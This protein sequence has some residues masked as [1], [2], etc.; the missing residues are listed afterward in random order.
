MICQDHTQVAADGSR[1]CLLWGNNAP[2]DVGGYARS[3]NWPPTQSFSMFSVFSG[4]SH[5]TKQ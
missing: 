2:T 3:A 4:H 5:F 1:R